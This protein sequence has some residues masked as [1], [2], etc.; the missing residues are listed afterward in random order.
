MVGAQKQIHRKKLREQKLQKKINKFLARVRRKF[1]YFASNIIRNVILNKY[2]SQSFDKNITVFKKNTKI[3][4][5][6]LHS[7]LRIHKG[8]IYVSKVVSK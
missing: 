2:T 3:P 6:Y 1:L 5:H 4:P 8:N 7:R